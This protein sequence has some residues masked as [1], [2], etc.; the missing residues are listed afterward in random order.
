MTAPGNFKLAAD[1]EA[2]ELLKGRMTNGGREDLELA[3][4]SRVG[5][6]NPIARDNVAFLEKVECACPPAGDVGI[7]EQ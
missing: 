6:I 5:Q 4:Q 7:A 3:C 2:V 1:A